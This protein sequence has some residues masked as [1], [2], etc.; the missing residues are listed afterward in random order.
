MDVQLPVYLHDV[1]TTAIPPR[2][3]VSCRTEA[4]AQD[5]A[6]RLRQAP[7][8]DDETF[9]VAAP[10]VALVSMPVDAGSSVV[11]RGYEIA[12]DV[13]AAALQP[14]PV[15]APPVEPTPAPLPEPEPVVVAP[16]PVEEP[17]P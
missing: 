9:I 3:I 13:L 16:P 4:A 6:Q 5:I 15:E 17:A 11:V 7:R 1:V 2:F 12:S 10:R 8:A 14:P